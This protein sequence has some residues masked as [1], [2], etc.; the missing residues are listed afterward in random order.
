[1]NNSYIKSLDKLAVLVDADN[2]SHK[3]IPDIMRTITT[4]GD[5]RIKR[6]FGDLRDDKLKTWKSIAEEHGF[7]E[8]HQTVYTSGKNATDI[9]MIIDAMKIMYTNKDIN[10][11]C[12]VTSDSD[13]TPLIHILKENSI[14]VYGFGRE[15]TPTPFKKSC[16]VFYDVENLK[17]N[18]NIC[19][20]KVKLD[21]KDKD[22]FRAAIKAHSLDNS[23]WVQLGTVRSHLGL[24]NNESHSLPK[25]YGYSSYKKLV[26]GNLDFFAVDPRQEDDRDPKNITY[27]IKLATV[28][29]EVVKQN[30][31]EQKIDIEN[32]DDAVNINANNIQNNHK[33]L[34]KSDLNI[35][36]KIF[37]EKKGEDGF[38]CIGSCNK[39]IKDAGINPNGFG[40]ATIPKLIKAYPSFFET[41]VVDSRFFVK[42]R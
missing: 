32:K 35:F 14:R 9:A 6:I 34:T 36:K 42:L 8:C 30:V 11:V 12:L 19:I 31:I 15:H 39:L 28:A 37:D 20:T 25:K 21:E 10:G 18:T 40:Y 7:V 26:D 22:D 27:Y 33:E 3:N 23:D 16:D 5:A 1:M 41:K 24:N 17:V 13:F 29:N 4:L 2:A 38:C